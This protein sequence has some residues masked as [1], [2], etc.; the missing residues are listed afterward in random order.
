MPLF[1]EFLSLIPAPEAEALLGEAIHVL[2]AIGER[3]ER[4]ASPYACTFK[5]LRSLTSV[6]PQPLTMPPIKDMDEALEKFGP[7][8]MGVEPLLKPTCEPAS[9][10]QPI[11]FYPAAGHAANATNAATPR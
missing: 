5:V 7:D 2:A 1:L 6:V 11:H 10:S 8:A 4:N 9:S 3:L